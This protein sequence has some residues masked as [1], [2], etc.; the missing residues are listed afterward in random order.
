MIER[1]VRRYTGN[2]DDAGQEVLNRMRF[3]RDNGYYSEKYQ[4]IPL[5]ESSPSSPGTEILRSIS[6]DLLRDLPGEGDRGTG[7]VY[8][9]DD[10][11]LPYGLERKIIAGL[12]DKGISVR[13]NAKGE[14]PTLNAITR[15]IN[16][17]KEGGAG[18]R[19]AS[20]ELLRQMGFQNRTREQ[21]KDALYRMSVV[22]RG[23]YRA[24]SES[25]RYVLDS[26]VL[27][28]FASDEEHGARP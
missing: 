27:E 21:I 5:I 14:Y 24:K 15:L 3:K 11:P 25:R 28:V 12:K 6:C 22:R 23:G 1:I 16:Y 4:I 19:R 2:V 18:G 17:L 20:Q 10:T 7:W 13:R 26:A 8:V 9:P